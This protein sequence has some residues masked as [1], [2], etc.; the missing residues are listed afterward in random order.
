MPL[1]CPFQVAG[2]LVGPDGQLLPADVAA[3]AAASAAQGVA[4][5]DVDAAQMQGGGVEDERSA[6]RVRLEGDEAG[7][8]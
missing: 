4:M 5:G 7:K 2:Q 1:P 6:K 3:A 8:V